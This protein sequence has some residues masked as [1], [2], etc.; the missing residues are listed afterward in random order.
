ML[1]KV[2]SAYV[3][4]VDAH[5]IEV[6][7]DISSVGLPQFSV[8]GLPDAAVKESRDRIRPALKN[9]GFQFPLKKI[10][11]NLAP[12][13]LKKEGSSF[14]LPIALGIIASEGLLEQGCLEGFMFVGELSLD[15]KLKPVRGVLPIAIEAHKRGFKGLVVPIENAKEAA[16]VEGL[17]VYGLTSLPETIEFLKGLR[18]VEPVTVSIEELM[19]QHSVYEEDFSEVK[20]QE[21]AKRALEVAATGSHNVLMIGPPGS[22]KTMLAKRLPTILPPMT[23]SEAIE[24]TKIHSVAG[25]LSDGTA[26]LAKRPVRMPHH[27]ISDVALIGGGQIPKPGEV[28]LA[29]YGVLFLDE[30]PEFKRNVLEVLRQPIENGYVTVSRAVATVTYPAQFVLV[31]AMNPCPCGHFG[32][33]L[34]Q[35]TCTPGL[36][37]RYRSKI[38]GPLLDRIDLH[39]EVPAVPF[40]ELSSDYSGERSETI[41]QRVIE[42][43]EIQLRRFRD[44]GIF[45]N[46]QMKT[47][48]IKKYCKLTEEAH[49]LLN[50][51]MQML[52]LSARAYSRILKVSRTIADL[53]KKDVIAGHHIGEAIQYRSLDRTLNTL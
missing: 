3:L 15:G 45:A 18:I 23:F 24:A 20:G 44:D 32:D 38:S 49:N 43:R 52:G 21:L 36:I 50:R 42:A 47:R 25:L 17:K 28:S 16:I 30:L 40:R 14:D 27:T 34:R 12:A 4:G 22:G 19:Q 13:D 35:C 41:R 29:H 37:A 33:P 51:A 31:A 46:G 1:S 48:H 9:I 6:E 2:L 8:V 39:I 26:I 10:T 11:V 53:D 7:V 5:L